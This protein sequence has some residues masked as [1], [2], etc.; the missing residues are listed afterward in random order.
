MKKSLLLL[1][2]LCAVSAVSNAQ[3]AENLYVVG[4][5]WGWDPKNGTELTKVSDGVFT[6]TYN[7]TS[8]SGTTF[9]SVKEGWD[10]NKP[11]SFNEHRYGAPTANLAPVANRPYE[12]KYQWQ[13]NFVLAAGETTVTVNTNT[14]QF[15]T[16]ATEPL[17][18]IYLVGPYAEGKWAPNEGMLLSSENGVFTGELTVEEA[19][20]FC[21]V[22]QLGA[23]NVDWD[24]FNAHRIGPNSTPALGIPAPLYYNGD[25]KY[26]L[27]PGSYVFELNTNDWT[28]KVEGKRDVVKQL[29]IFGQIDGKDWSAEAVNGKL[30]ES[31]D[32]VFTGE[33]TT[34]KDGAGLAFT[35][36]LDG[37]WNNVNSQRYGSDNINVM[38]TGVEVDV[39]YGGDYSFILNEGTYTYTLDT[40]NLKFIVEPKGE[41]EVKNT[42]YLIGDPAGEWALDKYIPLTSTTKVFEGEFTT[43]KVAEFAF[44]DKIC[45]SWDDLNTE[46]RFGPISNNPKVFPA[47]NEEEEVDMNGE[48]SFWAL[49]GSYSFVLDLDKHTFT[50]TGEH[51]QLHVMGNYL[52]GFDEWK[53]NEKTAMTHDGKGVYTISMGAVSKDHEF[54]IGDESWA[55]NFSTANKEMEVGQSYPLIYKHNDNMGVKDDAKNLELTADLKAGTLTVQDVTTGVKEIEV[56]GEV[57]YYNL[58]GVR[59]AAPEKGLYIVKKAGKVTKQMIR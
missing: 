44:A 45:T 16:A 35:K 25:R 30:I 40:N 7:L 37:V 43:S 46:H 28:L 32:G 56:A 33:F 3:K 51:T 2:A 53:P 20:G 24:T 58:Q 50:I 12:L 59:V 38:E 17:K 5:H 8:N 10:E 49:P 18:S 48:T 19:C 13:N 6:G 4:D 39:L 52:T 9:G 23:N 47:L 57:E 26:M 11:N 14:M 36:V 21:F 1:G 41:I 31:E 27:A 34:N 29:Y 55:A 22:D 15:Y 42:M 54:K